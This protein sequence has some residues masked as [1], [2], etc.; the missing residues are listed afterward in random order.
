MGGGGGGVCV[1]C[2]VVAW[3]G[4]RHVGNACVA[5]VVGMGGCMC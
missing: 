5:G 3:G 4:L 2:C 1:C